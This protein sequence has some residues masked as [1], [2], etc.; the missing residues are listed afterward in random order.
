MK[1]KF[2]YNQY[3]GSETLNKEYKEFTFHSAGLK[4]DKKIADDY[5]STNEFNFNDIVIKNIEK[6][7]DMY[8]PVNACASFNS[9]INSCFYIGVN[10]DGFVKGIPYK[11]DL[12]IKEI[13][14]YIYKK[15]SE[16][17]SNTSLGD[18]DFKKYV[19]I[20]ISKI[21]HPKKPKEKL[22]HEY[23]KYLRK[24]EKYKEKLEKYD[25]EMK[26]WRIRFAFV[27]Q[28]LFKI[29]NNLESRIILI[30][31]IKNNDPASPVIEL[32]KTDYKE[33]YQ[34]HEVV[35]LLKEDIT[36]PYYWVTRWKD[37]MIKKLRKERP[38]MIKLLPNV[39]I[40]LIMNVADMLPWWIHHN[41]DTTLNIIKVKILS[42]E[43]GIEFSEF[44]DNLF[45]YYDTIKK[46][47]L[48]YRRIIFN[49]GPSC[50][51]I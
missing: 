39:S 20:N 37:M 4:I 35:L 23:S 28:K 31:F 46:K 42:S 6:Y 41:E 22:N 19:K 29:I 40:N 1:T 32:L 11:G 50:F 33:I 2:K 18:I 12:P 9:N 51:P 48:K 49:G 7:I 8:L 16:N 17:L 34:P 27:N 43:F 10:D 13:E 45:S 26:D 36:S 30:E 44:S 21:N 25:E 15:L 14:K 3:L 47:W 5:C 24:K 38:P